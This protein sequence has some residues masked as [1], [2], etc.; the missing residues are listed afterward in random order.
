[1]QSFIGSLITRVTYNLF[2]TG[3]LLRMKGYAVWMGH[4]DHRCKLR[5]FQEKTRTLDHPLLIIYFSSDLVAIPCTSSDNFFFLWSILMSQRAS[6]LSFGSCFLVLLEWK[7][8]FSFFSC[9]PPLTVLIILY[10]EKMSTV[11]IM[12]C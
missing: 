9:L 1:M 10:T 7:N 3:S 2:Q 8:Y 12:Y 6:L 4:W 11:L 5:L